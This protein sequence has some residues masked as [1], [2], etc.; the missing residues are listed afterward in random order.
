[1]NFIKENR[2]I[3][4]RQK[5]KVYR[6]E[7]DF[8]FFE[9]NYSTRY[10]LAADAKIISDKFHLTGNF[11]ISTTTNFKIKGTG[12]LIES[13]GICFE[14]DKIAFYTK[15]CQ[16]HLS[17]IDGC[18]NTNLIDPFRNGD[19]CIN[20]L[21]FPAK[22]DQT[23]HTHP[24]LRIGMIV[25]GFGYA[26]INDERLDLKKGDIFFLPRNTKHRFCTDLNSMS[27]IV[28]HPDS[29][30]GPRDEHNPMKSRTYI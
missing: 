4:D 19:P 24:S 5:I 14:E 29:E 11:V 13:D 25:D 22:I 20:Y 28:F 1:M 17:Y 26:D 6:L 27:L 7:E 30:D 16:G 3:I 21:Y 15:G 9:S 12:I 18:S 2:T 8:Q 10:I 23:F